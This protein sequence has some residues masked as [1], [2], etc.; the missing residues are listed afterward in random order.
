MAFSTST[1]IPYTKALEEMKLEAKES[2]AI[3]GSADDSVS[4]EEMFKRLSKKKG[5]AL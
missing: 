5:D 1:N 3:G 2:N 4:D